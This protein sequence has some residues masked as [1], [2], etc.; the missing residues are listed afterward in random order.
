MPLNLLHTVHTRQIPCIETTNVHCCITR[1]PVA[2]YR[3]TINLNAA[4]PFS[5]NSYNSYSNIFTVRQTIAGE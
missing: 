2:L 5:L 4:Y 1:I 3:D